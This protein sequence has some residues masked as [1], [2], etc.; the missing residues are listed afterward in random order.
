M[1]EP[2]KTSVVLIVEDDAFLVKAYQIKLK[3][4]GVEVWTATDGATA[5]E[6]LK[7]DPPDLVLLDLMLPGISGFDILEKIRENSAWS[8]VPVM[9]LTNLGQPQDMERGK[10]LGIVDYIIKANTKISDIMLKIEHI[11]KK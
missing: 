7:K 2:T 1:T 8:K 3:K 4:M 6:F 5:L 10:K 11:L 9:I